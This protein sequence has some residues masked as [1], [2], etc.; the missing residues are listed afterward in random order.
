[1]LGEVDRVAKFW[2]PRM[3]NVLLYMTVCEQDGC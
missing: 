1:M 3:E 2:E